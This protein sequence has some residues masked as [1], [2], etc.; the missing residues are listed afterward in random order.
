[1][2]SSPM[3]TELLYFD[4]DMVDQIIDC[5]EE[6]TPNQYIYDVLESA[7]VRRQLNITSRE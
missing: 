4:D 6:A 7:W 2:I 5:V 1:M 3:L